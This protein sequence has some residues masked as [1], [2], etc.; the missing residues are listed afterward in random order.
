MPTPHGSSVGVRAKGGWEVFLCTWPLSSGC[1]NK[2]EVTFQSSLTE[3]TGLPLSPAG[4]SANKR[5]YSH[6]HSHTCLPKSFW[7]SIKRFLYCADK[8]FAV[9]TLL[10]HLFC[11]CRRPRL[12]AF[13][14]HRLTHEAPVFSCRLDCSSIISAKAAAVTWLKQLLVCCTE[15][16]SLESHIKMLARHNYFE[17]LISN[18]FLV[19]K[20]S[21]IIS[22]SLCYSMLLNVTHYWMTFNIVIHCRTTVG[23]RVSTGLLQQ[24]P[25]V[26]CWSGVQGAGAPKR[27]TAKRSSSFSLSRHVF[28]LFLS[29]LLTGFFVGHRVTACSFCEANWETVHDC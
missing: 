16:Y 11:L 6:T 17:Y 18:N 12:N 23:Q 22:P 21:S 25:W 26:W 13:L 1:G 7:S 8:S 14:F 9:Y 27:S 24:Q 5:W 29:C 2:D 19:L 4:G 3:Q 20:R 28:T 15:V 10:M